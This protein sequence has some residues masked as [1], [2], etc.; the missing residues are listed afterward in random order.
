VRSLVVLAILSS[1]AAVFAADDLKLENR[2]DLIKKLALDPYISSVRVK[3]RIRDVKV[4]IID[5]G[6]GKRENLVRDLPLGRYE[7]VET[8][9]AKLIETFKL[10]NPATQKALDGS[11]HG[12]QMAM[13]FFSL[14]CPDKD[15]CPFVYLL[16]GNGIT[17]MERA[18][19]FAIENGVKIV[20][21]ARNQEYGG[22]FDGRGYLNGVVSQ[23][24]SRLIWINAAGNYG[25]MVHNAQV[26][27]DRDGWLKFTTKSGETTRLKL[28]SKLARNSM[29]LVLAWNRY[30]DVEES[31]TDRDLD[32]YVYDETG[33]N[34]LKIK[35]A[36]GNEREIKSTLK[37]VV[38]G[39]G[40]TLQPGESFMPR[41][42]ID[43]EIPKNADGKSFFLRAMAK[44]PS[45]FDATDRVRITIV[46]QGKVVDAIEFEDATEGREIMIPADNPLVIAVGD[47][48]DASANGP[49]MDGRAKPEVVLETSVTQFND[50]DGSS[51][52]S[53]AS[54]LFAGVVA[55]MK[56]QEPDLT[57][58]DVLR[59]VKKTRRADLR[60]PGE[61]QGIDNMK[62]EDVRAVHGT[63][64][65]A[66]NEIL[67]TPNG[68][69][70][71][72]LAGRYQS[73]GPYVIALDRSPLELGTTF[74]LPPRDR[75]P[76][77]YEIF[78][79]PYRDG[80]GRTGVWCYYRDRARAQGAP[81][82]R[83]EEDLKREPARFVR[84][85]RARRIE[86][87]SRDAQEL[88]IWRTPA[89]ADARGR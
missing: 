20:L 87:D 21:Y 85:T 64:I 42:I 67:G 6:F 48:T 18:V 84:V 11:E 3:D 47:L 66:V 30:T 2:A 36:D 60:R 86:K 55:L 89:P 22:N 29:K 32:F 7:V 8:Y 77:H 46:P 15:S 75:N 49:T 23:A 40:V 19:R 27:A 76:D 83:W 9:D 62:I 80:F 50:G 35:G 51:G 59:H 63:V 82:A 37:Q 81:E 38:G 65:D 28:K 10:G 56:A 57:R 54:A 12:R 14:A 61:T 74:P 13:S 39:A 26:S 69:S 5:Q 31:G 71:V 34:I 88:P 58:E 70:P 79:V 44:D 52:T 45:K 16:N 25:K 1:V 4:A 41:E 33:S 68:R 53:N 17:N 73:N 43:A 72:V 78:L 24:A